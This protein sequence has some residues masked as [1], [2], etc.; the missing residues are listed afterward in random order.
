MVR[1]RAR[2]REVRY[3]RS[4]KASGLEARIEELRVGLQDVGMAKVGQASQ[5][6]AAWGRVRV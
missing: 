3:G 1:R 6:C 4:A 2:R 5:G